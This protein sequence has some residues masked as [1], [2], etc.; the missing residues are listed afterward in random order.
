VENGNWPWKAGC[1]LDIA[2]IVQPMWDDD[3]NW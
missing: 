2:L 1:W 3:P